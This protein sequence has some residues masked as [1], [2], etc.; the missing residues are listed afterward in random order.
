ML[1]AWMVD[2][3]GSNMYKPADDP[4]YGLVR[5]SQ[6]DI[7]D[8]FAICFHNHRENL[9]HYLP[10]YVP[11]LSVNSSKTSDSHCILSGPIY[12]DRDKSMGRLPLS[13]QIFSLA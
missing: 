4:V 2:H 12:N 7:Q 10:P 11:F 5:R 13:Q 9:S 3:H 1:L 6:N 8:C